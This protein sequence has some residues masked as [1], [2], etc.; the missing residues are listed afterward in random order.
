MAPLST[1][2]IIPSVGN[3]FDST[4]VILTGDQSL[5]VIGHQLVY[6]HENFGGGSVYEPNGPGYAAVLA[7]DAV[8]HVRTYQRAFDTGIPRNTGKLRIRGVSYNAII[9]S[10]AS[11][12]GPT[13]GHTGGAAIYVKVPGVSGWLDLGRDYGVPDLNMAVDFRGCKTGVTPN[14]TSTDFTVSFTTGAFTSNNGVGEFPLHILVLL[15]KNGAGQL[16]AIDDITW[17]AP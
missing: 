2:T 6:P 14:T 15:F 16:L 10:T 9:S 4:V 1:D 5:Q 11:P 13:D 7:G 3:K 8:N 17:E 12:T